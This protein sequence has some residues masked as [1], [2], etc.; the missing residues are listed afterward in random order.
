MAN[1]FLLSGRVFVS[2]VAW[3][4]AAVAASDPR[5][6]FETIHAHGWG[7]GTPDHVNY[8]MRNDATFRGP[9][10]LVGGCEL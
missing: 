6:F 10:A 9:Y 1:G 8:M 3:Y 4:L 7:T 5:T 2:R